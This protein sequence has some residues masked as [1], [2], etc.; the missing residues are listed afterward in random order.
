MRATLEKGMTRRAC[1]GGSTTDGRYY[2]F[3]S[4]C[5]KEQPTDRFGL[6]KPHGELRKDWFIVCPGP[7]SRVRN[8]RRI[9]AIMNRA[10]ARAA[11]RY[12]AWCAA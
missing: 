11:S 6:L 8:D 9:L 10:M 2:G 1:H 4:T 12:R 3:C 7:P 5:W